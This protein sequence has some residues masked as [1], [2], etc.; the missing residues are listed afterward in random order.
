LTGKW[1]AVIGK[2]KKPGLRVEESV[3][4]MLWQNKYPGYNLV[5]Q[6]GEVRIYEKVD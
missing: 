4:Y 1:Y 5:H 2:A 3:A 6:E